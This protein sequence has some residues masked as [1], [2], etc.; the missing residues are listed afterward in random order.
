MTRTRSSRTGETRNRRL[1]SRATAI[2]TA[3]V[4]P[5]QKVRLPRGTWTLETTPLGTGGF[6]SVYAGKSGDGGEVA[7]KRLDALGKLSVERELQA[8][9]RLI[10]RNLAH[11]LPILDAGR[12]G[13]NAFVVMARASH[14]LASA[15]QTRGV[16]AESEAVDVLRQIAAGLEEI[17]DIVHRD[18]KP[19][20]VLFHEGSWKVADFGLVRLADASTSLHTVRM[21]FTPAYAAPEQWRGEHSTHATDVYAL[22]CIGYALL[23]GAPP[24][25]GPAVQDLQ[26]QHLGQAP[27]LLEASPALR[28]LLI[29]CL[30]KSPGLRPALA[31]IRVEL[32]RATNPG[33]PRPLRGLQEVAAHLAAAEATEG[34]RCAALRGQA[35][36]RERAAQAGLQGSRELLKEFFERLRSAA[37][38][39]VLSSDCRSIRLGRAS[40]SYKEAF[41]LLQADAFPRSQFPAMA[42]LFMCLRQEK[43]SY[44]GRSSNLWLAKLDGD[45]LGW[46]EAC[47]M[48]SPFL[49]SRRPDE[50]FGI[51][52]SRELEIADRAAGPAMDTHQYAMKLTRVDGDGRE[53]FIERWAERFAAAAAGA[54]GHPRSLP[55]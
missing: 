49:Q 6:G 43:A 36:E 11:V 51:E 13:S 47:Y 25:R 45:S 5:H 1:A 37:P 2:A 22:G 52:S 50:P 34:A 41:P 17:G 19:A 26:A 44:P 38:N 33:S 12:D 53:A 31:E 55:E 24:F 18:L 10:G 30:E 32:Q 35:E 20:N 21:A 27:S 7:V 4:D 14:S 48:T 15:I 16:F 23:T 9:E 28:L 29:R 46:W 8:A 39:A 42:G 54:L 40:V 3:S